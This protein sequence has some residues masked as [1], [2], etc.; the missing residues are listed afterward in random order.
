MLTSYLE[1]GKL[2]WTKNI[3][4][5]DG[6]WAYSHEEINS[7]IFNLHWKLES[8]NNAEKPPE[9]DLIILRQK[10][11]VTHIVELL[12]NHAKNN[13]YHQEKWVYRL[14]KA[15]WMA[16]PWSEPPHQDDVFGCQ[17]NL[18]GGNIMELKNIEAFK[19]RWNPDEGMGDFHNHITEILKLENS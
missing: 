1:E 14:V 10:G 16:E 17:I 18:Q 2:K 5:E 9:K 19:K 7:K 6:E 13:D 11:K 3:N 8:Y 15:V 12:D 4:R